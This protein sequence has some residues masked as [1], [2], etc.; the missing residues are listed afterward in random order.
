MASSEQTI[1][2]N[3]LRVVRNELRQLH[4]EDVFWEKASDK[5][6]LEPVNICSET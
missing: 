6:S 1:G 3:L 2:P 4:C 5:I